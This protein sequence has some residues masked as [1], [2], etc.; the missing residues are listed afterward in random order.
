MI[1]LLVL[2]PALLRWQMG[3]MMLFLMSPFL[4]LI[5]RL[6]LLVDAD[7]GTG[8]ANDVIVLLPDLLMFVAGMGFVMNLRH[9]KKMDLKFDDKEVRVPLIL[10]IGLNVIE[11]FN[12]FMGSVAA[13][14]KST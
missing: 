6:Y 12:P 1:A 9:Q 13:G 4:S 14:I 11:I 3:W 5:R 8:S 7:M 10:F 2:T